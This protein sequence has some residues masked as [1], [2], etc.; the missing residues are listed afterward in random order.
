MKMMEKEKYKSFKDE[1]KG[2]SRKQTAR[3]NI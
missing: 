3:P 1:I 2:C